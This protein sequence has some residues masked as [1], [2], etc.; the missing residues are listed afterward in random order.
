MKEYEFLPERTFQWNRYFY[1][2]VHGN[3]DQNGT[4]PN[5]LE[6]PYLDDLSEMEE[7]V[8]TRVGYKMKHEWINNTTDVIVNDTVT[9]KVTIQTLFIQAF[10]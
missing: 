1:L 8:A 10:A 9:F 3:L 6:G 7:E 4:Y 2:V 5:I